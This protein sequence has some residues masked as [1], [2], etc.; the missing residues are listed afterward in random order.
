IG[1]GDTRALTPAS[2]PGSA[3]KIVTFVPESHLEQSKVIETLDEC[4]IV[5]GTKLEEKIIR[6]RKFNPNN[7]FD[8]NN[9]H[10]I[11]F[12]ID[13]DRT[14]ECLATIFAHF[15]GSKKLEEEYESVVGSGFAGMEYHPNAIDYYDDH[16]CMIN[17]LK[18]CFPDAHLSLHA[19]E[20]NLELSQTSQPLQTHVRKAVEVAGA[21]RIGHGTCS[22]KDLNRDDLFKSMHEKDVHVEVNLNSNKYVVGV[23]EDDHPIF[24]FINHGVSFSLCTDDQ[25]VFGSSLFEEMKLACQEYGKKGD[26]N[27]AHHVLGY[28]ELKRSVLNSARKCFLPGKSIYEHPDKF[29]RLV[30][31]KDFIS[32]DKPLSGLR[33]IISFCLNPEFGEWAEDGVFGM[34]TTKQQD[35]IKTS[36]KAQ[37]ELDLEMAFIYFEQFVVPALI[38]KKSGKIEAS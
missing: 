25:G 29:G 35:F 37:L 21:E 5:A 33:E 36:E 22:K 32:D 24:E 31:K 3:V 8:I 6:G 20:L 10:V 18:Q 14:E 15:V 16:M 11:R 9:P 1:A 27:G 17:I 19:G 30:F 34:L 2:G 4:K 38:R 26:R 7:L 13:N 28:E 23:T 12:I